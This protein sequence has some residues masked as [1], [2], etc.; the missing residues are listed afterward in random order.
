[1]AAQPGELVQDEKMDEE[2][3]TETVLAQDVDPIDFLD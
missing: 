3:D 2:D 1:M